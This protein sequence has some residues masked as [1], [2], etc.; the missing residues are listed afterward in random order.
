MAGMSMRR[1]HF[2]KDTQS[3][4]TRDEG[5]AEPSRSAEPTGTAREFRST[6]LIVVLAILLQ[7]IFIYKG[8]LLVDPIGVDALSRMG[9]PCEERD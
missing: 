9:Y 4:P 1:G 5:L 7:L 3:S 6:D 8:G 2:E